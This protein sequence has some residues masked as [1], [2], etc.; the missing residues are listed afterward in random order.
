V[1]DELDLVVGADG[2]VYENLK[3]FSDLMCI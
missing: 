2:H 1:Y 3:P